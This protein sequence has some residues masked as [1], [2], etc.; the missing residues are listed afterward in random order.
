MR[1]QP[2]ER[3]EATF[4]KCRLKAATGV[5]LTQ[6]EAIPRW[7]IWADWIEVKNAAIKD[8]NNICARKNCT[9]MRSAASTR[10][11]QRMHA[12]SPSKFRS[13]YAKSLHFSLPLMPVLCR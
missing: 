9:Y 6:D 2:G 10:H 7:I 11:I 5:S 3:E 13:A 4:C 12:N 8:C 1:H